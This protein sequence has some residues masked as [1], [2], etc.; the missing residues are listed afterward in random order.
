MFTLG[1]CLMYRMTSDVIAHYTRVAVATSQP[2]LSPCDQNLYLFVIKPDRLNHY[3]G[4]GW[5]GLEVFIQLNELRQCE[6][7]CSSTR[8]L[9]WVL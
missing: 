7:N 4:G 8:I 6:Q 5:Q 9:T 3:G 1:T 2:V